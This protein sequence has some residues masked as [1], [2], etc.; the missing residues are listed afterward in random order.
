VVLA[1]QLVNA[2][3]GGVLDHLPVMLVID[4]SIKGLGLEMT[5][6]VAGSSA[7]GGQYEQKYDCQSLL[8][9]RWINTQRQSSSTGLYVSQQY[10]HESWDGNVTT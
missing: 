10:S 6:N 7:G 8:D 4:A 9:V 5:D 3:M 1:W 2:G